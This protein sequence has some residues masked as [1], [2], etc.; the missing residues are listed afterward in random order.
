MTG[1]LASGEPTKVCFDCCKVTIVAICSE[2][3]DPELTPVAFDDPEKSFLCPNGGGSAIR[4]VE[5]SVSKIE[6]QLA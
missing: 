5:Q 2:S 3:S 1:I 6:D 4:S